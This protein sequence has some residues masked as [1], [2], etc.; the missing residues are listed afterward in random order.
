MLRTQGVP[1]RLATGYVS[2]A[3]DQDLGCLRGAGQRRPRLGRSVVPRRRLA[4]VRPDRRR[5]ARRPTPK[6]DS[7][8]ADL[9]AGVG[10]YVGDQPIR[11][12][13]FG[14]ARFAA[15]VRCTGSISAVGRAPPTGSVGR[16]AGSLR[17]DRIA[18][19]SERRSAEPCLGGRLDR[20][21]R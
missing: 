5:A 3:R 6:I 9:A 19:R 17:G 20:C 1:A 8:G 18:T 13:L 4:G 11:V 10:D 15:I 21:R 16:T 12:V 7:V 2:G 14:A